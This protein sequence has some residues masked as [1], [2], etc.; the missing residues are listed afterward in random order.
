[1]SN[2]R[3]SPL[4]GP[5]KTVTKAKGVQIKANL[6]EL[7]LGNND[8]HQNEAEAIEALFRVRIRDCRRE[9]PAQI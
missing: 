6:S 7:S 1:V 8:N 3:P 9:A 2:K 4:K 5:H